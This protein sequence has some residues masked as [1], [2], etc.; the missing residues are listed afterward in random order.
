MATNRSGGG[1]GP[2]AFILGAI[3]ILVIGI[4]WYIGAGSPALDAPGGAEITAP[5]LDAPD[6]DAPD[7]DAPDIVEPDAVDPVDPAPEAEPLPEG[8]GTVAPAPA[9][10]D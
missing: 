1:M 2:W 4:I 10:A 6:V 9:P 3:V 8:G 5:D 7:A